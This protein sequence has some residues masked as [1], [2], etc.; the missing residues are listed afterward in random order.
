M[1]SYN[2]R[3][4]LLG[5]IDFNVNDYVWMGF[6]GRCMLFKVGVDTLWY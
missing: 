5:I 4:L 1:E 3:K 6:L 2:V